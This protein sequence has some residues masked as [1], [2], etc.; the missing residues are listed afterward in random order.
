MRVLIVEDEDIQRIT[1]HDELEEAG[2]KTTSTAS[3]QIALDLLNKM[4]FE[5]ILTD[6]KMPEMDGIFFVKR[7]L[8]VQPEVTPIVMT[9]YGTAES[10]VEAMRLGVYHYLIKP[11]RTD[12]LMLL[13]KRVQKYRNLL[14]ENARLRKQLDALYVGG[15]LSQKNAV[16]QNTLRHLGGGTKAFSERVARLETA[17]ICKALAKSG[18]NITSAAKQLNIPVSTLKYKIKKYGIE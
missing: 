3:V 13:L 11:F 4:S 16:M 1:L 17:L 9:A 18:G 14:A 12:E 10:A 15:T 6:L 8:A 5:V 7:A 2:Y